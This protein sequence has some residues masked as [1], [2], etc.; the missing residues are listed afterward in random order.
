MAEDTTSSCPLVDKPNMTSHVW[1]H[2]AL[3]PDTDGKS[4]EMDKPRCK[5]CFEEVIV[6]FR[7]T[8]DLF[9]HLRHKH[10]LVYKNS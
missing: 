6:R 4:K 10:P 2:F 9:A 8:S 5:L 3:V 7:N 1:R